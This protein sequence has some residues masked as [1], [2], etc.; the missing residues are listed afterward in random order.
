VAAE[1]ERTRAKLPQL[2]AHLDH[3]LKQILDP[4][5]LFG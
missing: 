2:A 5:G 3:E 4:T 1:V